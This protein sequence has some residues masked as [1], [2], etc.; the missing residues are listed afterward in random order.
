MTVDV[1][2]QLRSAAN[3]IGDRLRT[4]HIPEHA[5][6]SP[7]RGTRALPRVGAALV[8]LIGAIGVV[9]V[10]SS[11]HGVRRVALSQV[12][13]T[14]PAT[15]NQ[16]ATPTSTPTSTST[17]TPTSAALPT[18][19]IT[20]A[21]SATES[22]TPTDPNGANGAPLTATVDP[23]PVAFGVV[24]DGY[25]VVLVQHGNTAGGP[26]GSPSGTTWTS[27]FISTAANDSP[28]PFIQVQIDS[29][30]GDDPYVGFPD[31]VAA[32][33]VPVGAFTG[34]ISTATAGYV[35]FVTGLGGGRRMLVG[36]RTTLDEVNAVVEGLT[37]RADGTRADVSTVP[38]GYRAIGEQP[39]ATGGPVE[40]WTVAYANDQSMTS[41]VTISA[42]RNP[43]F[44]AIYNLLSPARA[45]T[46][47]IKGF[48]AYPSP[49]GITFDVT[50]TFQ[51]NIS[52][53]PTTTVDIDAVAALARRLVAI[54]TAELDRLQALA[55]GQGLAPTDLPCSLYLTPKRGAES[56]HTASPSETVNGEVQIH[57]PGSFTI[58]ITPRQPVGPVTISVRNHDT[59]ASTD[60]DHLD[61]LSNA[62]TLT[63][64][65]DGTITGAP[66]PAGTY[67]VMAHADPPADR[68]PGLC[69][70]SNP[71]DGVPLDAAFVVP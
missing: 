50:P 39:A 2:Q 30:I 34:R 68:S 61:S 62:T 9:A 57:S 38:N 1:E 5:L 43:P 29:S 53:D 24:P 14:V 18:V 17:I 66:A 10:V 58:D 40:E 69:T 22:S 3:D 67:D 45:R 46:L 19:A 36:G 32:R 60:I 48:T 8:V 51:V 15:S 31:L 56:V 54:S 42:R 44:P 23:G 35:E 12:P 55:A 21:V 65:W 4:A 33:D 25:R 64:S 26:W 11:R 28:A 71:A 59:G 13:T 37:I 47:D 16:P 70:T 7:H 52:V 49:D 63:V 20:S 41:Q 6:A 27:T